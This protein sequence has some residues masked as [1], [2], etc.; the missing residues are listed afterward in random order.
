MVRRTAHG[1]VEG[2]YCA[3]TVFALHRQGVFAALTAYREPQALARELG[4][5]LESFRAVL[6]FLY[7]TTDL[8][9]RSPDGEY[10]LARKYQ[11]YRAFGFHLDKFLGAY[12][13]P[14]A[15]LEESLRLPA[16]G[17]RL[18]DRGRL[19]EA[20][21]HAETNG[22]TTIANL[23][24]HAG[25]H[26]VMD[27]GCGTAALLRELGRSDPTF[28]GW[29]VDVDASMCKAATAAIAAAGLTQQIRV[30]CADVRCIGTRL[31][32]RERS[33][34][35]ALVGRS[36]FNEFC[37][38]GGVEAVRVLARLRRLFPGRRLFVA[39]YYGKLTYS[40]V[41][42][43]RFRHTVLQDLAQALTAQGIPPPNLASWNRLY[44][45]GGCK[46]AE[47]YEG[48]ADGIEWF[49]HV[50]EL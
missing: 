25:V 19:A 4:Y 36:L 8:L 7:W 18:V 3:Q 42:S 50:V 27:L 45:A 28:R 34:V 39:D 41:P 38:S 49:F 5:D 31:C 12:G 48:E 23:I 14:L 26:S 16:E 33:C 46:L 11:P 22:A 1:V 32:P 15:R 21:S 24:R 6:E 40:M 29:A 37:R 43:A 20:F 13:E 47:A 10:R 35:E 44:L 30:V 17:R 2:F 9:A